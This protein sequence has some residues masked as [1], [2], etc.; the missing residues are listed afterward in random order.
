MIED[1]QYEYLIKF[2][3]AGSLGKLKREM[4]SAQKALD[5]MTK[6]AE[7]LQALTSSLGFSGNPKQQLAANNLAKTGGAQASQSNA[8][9]AG[10]LARRQAQI[11]EQVIRLDQDNH[12]RLKKHYSALQRQQAQELAS[13][14]R[15]DFLNREVTSLKQAQVK[16]EAAKLRTALA[17]REFLNNTDGR[18]TGRLSKN[19]AN[20]QADEAEAIANAERLNTL[21]RQ[22]ETIAK[23]RSVIQEKLNNSTAR[24]NAQRAQGNNL[25]ARKELLKARQLKIDLLA[26]QQGKLTTA[27]INQQVIAQNRLNAAKAR[28]ANSE[29]KDLFSSRLAD[30]GAGLFKIQAQLLA[31]YA[32]MG[33]A[34]GALSFAGKFIVDLDRE[35]SQLQAITGTTDQAMQ[36]LEKTIISVSEKTKFTALEVAEAATI[37][38]Q[39]GFSTDAIES[40]IQSITLLAT[41]V[42]S[43]LKTTVD[44]VTSTLSVF[45]LRAEEAGNVANV[46]TS[47]VNNSKLNLEKLTLGLQYA[48]NIANEQNISFSELTATLGAMANSGIRAGSTLGTGL[49]QILTALA[50][51]SEKLS[52]RL[53]DLGLASEDVD[54][55]LHGFTGVL[56]NLQTAGFTTSDALEVLEVRAGAAFAALTNNIG[57]IDD[58]RKK[59]LL[60][61]AAAKA[62]EVQMEALA[63]K[64]ARLQSVFGTVVAKGMAPLLDVAKALVDVL[65][66]LLSG[67]N[68]LGPVLPIL[69][70]TVT[71]L[72]AAFLYKRVQLLLSNTAMLASIKT[73]VAT[74]VTMVSLAASAKGLALSLGPVGLALIAVTGLMVAS[75]AGYDALTVS[76]DELQAKLDES[77]GRFE[78]YRQNLVAIDKE[79]DRLTKRH[80]DASTSM[81]EVNNIAL[82]LQQKF[83]DLGAKFNF[84]TG[85]LADLIPELERLRDVMLELQE[86]EL[87]SSLIDS[88]SLLKKQQKIT[89]RVI[90]GVANNG[91]FGKGV[92]AGNRTLGEDADVQAFKAR[93]KS[94]KTLTAKELE[95]FNQV[96]SDKLA[97]ILDRLLA[98]PD[99][100]GEEEKLAVF[101][102]KKAKFA[103]E[104][105]QNEVLQMIQ[106]TMGIE[107]A[108]MKLAQNSFERSNA[109]FKEISVDLQEAKVRFKELRAAGDKEGVKS[110][111]KEIEDSLGNARDKF[112]GD[113]Q[114]KF[115]ASGFT[116]AYEGLHHL[117]EQYTQ[118]T[119]QELKEEKALHDLEMQIR[120]RQLNNVMRDVGVRENALTIA[121]SKDEALKLLSD[122]QAKE[123]TRELEE[124][125]R[126]NSSEEVINKTKTLIASREIEEREKVINAFDKM[127]L[128][129]IVKKQTTSFKSLEQSLEADIATQK[130]LVS[131]RSS[132]AD[133]EQAKARALVSLGKLETAAREDLTFRLRNDSAQLAIEMVNLNNTLASNRAA[134]GEAFDNLHQDI[135]VKQAP[136]LRDALTELVNSFEEARNALD[137]KIKALQDPVK[138]AQAARDA[139]DSPANKG[140]FSDVH[141]R[142]M[143][144]KVQEAEIKA[145]KAELE[146]LK[147]EKSLELNLQAA[148]LEVQ[149]SINAKRILELQTK[150]DNYN[151]GNNT[152]SMVEAKA[153]IAEINQL[154]KQQAAI[155]GK[156]L[157]KKKEIAQTT[158]EI[159]D[160][161]RQIGVETGTSAPKQYGW[162][163][164]LNNG[165]EDYME[166]LEDATLT[167][168]KFADKVGEVMGTFTDELA[169]AF[170]DVAIGAK[171]IGEAFADMAAAVL[172]AILKIL[173]EQAAIFAVKMLL[174]A[175]GVPMQSAPQGLSGGGLVAKAP[176]ERPILPG[177]SG[178]GLVPRVGVM[179]RDTTPLIGMPGEFMLKKSA[180]DSIGK[181]KLHAMNI[182]GKDA[183]DLNRPNIILPSQQAEKSEVNVYVVS[184]DEK[185]SLT[186]KDV[187][188]V[189]GKD[190]VSG[191]QTKQLIKKVA[192]S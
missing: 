86:V 33:L 34:L 101:R 21:Q 71:A 170:Y 30:G 45:N 136:K 36:S 55:K 3:D 126:N 77:L 43:D 49:R 142:E 2:F 176:G 20:A 80:F 150:I 72:G 114:A 7:G 115:D 92:L 109:D 110:F 113:N 160:L 102:D 177:L 53:R 60:S 64:G 131:T 120:Q 172:K 159:R 6:S 70:T 167:S 128:D 54:V 62:N 13:L 139:M 153:A 157:D 97:P 46:F 35:F 94:G 75:K 98:N 65:A 104:T 12:N 63:N 51:P 38:G 24:M 25:E 76:V 190:I 180:V 125:E 99:P 161:E 22:G 119:A 186:P 152:T 182:M 4:A 179:G 138:D 188:Y 106:T 124:L 189:I 74:R 79:I 11:A 130:K 158:E 117:A 166:K 41:A 90:D 61:S 181:D 112:S 144:R 18:S 185:P 116:K 27:Q 132:V 174:R 32:A 58:L 108:R 178:G 165:L 149:S 29:K 14:S 156:I 89:S 19:L 183:L 103:Y 140:K 118:K 173:A 66:Y 95:D 137:A 129:E 42:G 73:M 82:E 133:I 184:P 85:T 17:S 28:V 37:L 121:I 87:K 68:R 10:K 148:E 135:T 162:M 96:L 123:R 143:D 151:T 168:E 83:A 91:F 111:V 146:L 175:F 141:R 169:D 16:A 67:L 147:S 59:F 164:G 145:M 23:R 105:L 39:A 44:L 84:T 56:E 78:T 171:S 26:T 48:G 8:L 31:N 154:N 40:S 50:A 100:K 191:G 163:E 122:K 57:T 15:Q 81:T 93:S 52:A 187:L 9:V 88:Q 5:K 47:A 1:G 155:Q 127:A 69:T 192:L 134:L 107:D